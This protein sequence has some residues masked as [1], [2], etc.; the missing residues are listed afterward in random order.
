VLIH[1]IGELVPQCVMALSIGAE[2]L[3]DNMQ[4]R[5]LLLRVCVGL[6]VVLAALVVRYLALLLTG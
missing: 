4:N 1:L 6:F 5:S 3:P 2:K